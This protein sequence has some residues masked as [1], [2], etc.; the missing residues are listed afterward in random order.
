MKYD[1][2]AWR[3]KYL[4][5]VSL[6]DFGKFSRK[7][8]HIS[9]L[10]PL[11]TKEPALYYLLQYNR[12]L[13]HAYDNDFCDWYEWSMVKGKSTTAWRKLTHDETFDFHISESNNPAKL[14]FQREDPISEYEL[15]DKERKDIV[16]SMVISGLREK[17]EDIKFTCDTC[18]ARFTCTLRF[19]PYNTD[20]DCL[21]DK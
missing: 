21:Q 5:S 6:E 17:N 4:D 1:T 3:A 15:M 13:R 14:Y 12:I 11:A 19:D 20:G 7:F 16:D 2:E 9:Y 8:R 18:G 10:K